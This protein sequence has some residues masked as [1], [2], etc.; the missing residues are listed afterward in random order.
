MNT[1]FKLLLFFLLFTATG[2]FIFQRGQSDKVRK[3]EIK[4]EK[5]KEKQKKAYLTSQKKDKKRRFDMQ[6]ADTKKR[7]KETKKKARKINNQNHESFFEKL[8]K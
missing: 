7:M 8:F 4:A 5:V 1:F 2:C 3:A 6:S